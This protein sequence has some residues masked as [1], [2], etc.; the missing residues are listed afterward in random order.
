MMLVLFALAPLSYGLN[1]NRLTEAGIQEAANTLEQ[2]EPIAA[3]FVSDPAIGKGAQRALDE[4]RNLLA[5]V[6]TRECA[7]PKNQQSASCAKMR[8]GLLD[9]HHTISRALK[10]GEDLGKFSPQQIEQLTNARKLL[11]GFIEYVPFWV[12]LLSALV[13]GLGTAVG[14]EKIVVTLGEK[15]GSAHMNPAQGTA[16]QA[17]AIIG[18]GLANF[19]GMPVS[20]THVLS[21]AVLGSVAG[22]KGE[23]VNI[24]TAG[25]IAITW[26]TT[27]PGTV[28][29][30]FILSVIF[31]LALV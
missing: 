7:D 18:L 31:Y 26:F 20:T 23:K 6:S 19:G 9:L 22:T 14:Y 17:S 13:L 2:V 30:S 11:G 15:M 24:H 16:A 3:Q 5:L 4:T 8:A 21:A 10:K 28:I 27:L 1:S 12:I 25:K 29:V